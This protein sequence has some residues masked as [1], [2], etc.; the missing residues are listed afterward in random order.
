MM[1]GTTLML[2]AALILSAGASM[3][4]TTMI[5]RAGEWEVTVSNPAINNGAPIP[6]KIC[7]GTDRAI[8]DLAAN[9]MM[10]NCNVKISGATEKTAVVDATCEAPNHITITTHTVITMI[11][12]DAYHSQGTAHM[13]GA[14]AGAPT[15]SAFTNDAKRLGPCQAGETPR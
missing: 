2:A 13:D 12:E 5:R 9:P 3:A 14:P 4:D 15:D 7:F 6:R 1:T 10:K 8:S 11:G